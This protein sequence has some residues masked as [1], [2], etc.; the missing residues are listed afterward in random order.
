MLQSDR[1][2]WK[3]LVIPIALAWGLVPRAAA[4]AEPVRRP[5]CQIR[6]QSIGL[7]SSGWTR[8]IATDPHDENVLWGVAD[9][10]GGI[11]RTVNGGRSWEDFTE[12]AIK[13]TRCGSFSYVFV[14]P[15]GPVFV[16]TR[17]A[18]F[19]TL[20]QGKGWKRAEIRLERDPMWM[21][22]QPQRPDLVFLVDNLG[23]VYRSRDRG[24]TWETVFTQPGKDDLQKVLEYR[25]AGYWAKIRA[26]PCPMSPGY[27]LYRSHPY[28]GVLASHDEGQTWSAGNAG[29]PHKQVVSIDYHLDAQRAEL[30]L[31]ALLQARLSARGDGW[32]GGV[33]VSADGGKSWFPRNRGIVTP[34]PPKHLA[35][36]LP[37]F[38]SLEVSKKVRGLAYLLGGELYA[39]EVA[40]LRSEDAG[41]NW[42]CVHI[43]YLNV[44]TDGKVR[45]LAR[46]PYPGMLSLSASNP[47][48]FY[49]NAC[50]PMFR[51]EK[52][53]AV[54]R[55]IEYD[56]IDPETGKYRWLGISHVCTRGVA[57]DPFKNYVHTINH[58]VGYNRADLDQGIVDFRSLRHSP[59]A[60]G[61]AI[62]VDPAN[63]GWV[64]FGGSEFSAYSEKPQKGAV[65]ASTDYGRTIAFST[66]GEASGLPSG[67]IFDLALDLSG[68][69]L[70]RRLYA[71]VGG[72][73]VFASRD[74]GRTWQ[75]IHENLPAVSDDT[76]QLSVHRLHVDSEGS[77][78]AVL[79]AGPPLLAFGRIGDFTGNRVFRRTVA[80]GLWEELPSTRQFGGNVFDVVS[81][82]GNPQVLY[83][84]AY[85]GVFQSNNAGQTWRRV[86]ENIPANIK[87]PCAPYRLA[88]HPKKPDRVW[89]MFSGSVRYED[90]WGVWV[91]EDA[92]ATW[93]EANQG[94]A[95]F[96]LSDL[97][98]DPK[99]PN[100]VLVAT[101]GVGCFRGAFD[102][103]PVAP[104]RP[105]AWQPVKIRPAANAA[106]LIRNGSAEEVALEK[107]V[108]W[109]IYVGQVGGPVVWG[110]SAEGFR[111]SKCAFI[112]V[113]KL[114]PLTSRSRP[115]EGFIG[116]ALVPAD[117]DGCRARGAYPAEPGKAYYLSF[118]IKG[119][120]PR[121]AIRVAGW[122]SLEP[123]DAERST[124]LAT[125]M[126]FVNPTREWQ[127]Y[128][129]FFLTQRGT[130]AFA[131]TFM[132]RGYEG[133]GF[134]PGQRVYVDDVVVSPLDTTAERAPLVK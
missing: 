1:S 107:P 50:S 2:T 9:M 41:Q 25:L 110:T 70:Q 49:S 75:K 125:S 14:H 24:Q 126:Q 56:V 7:A 106:N 134:Q 96:G 104:V 21:E 89:V 67:Y 36:H 52:R 54:A 74:G 130:R 114:Y 40:L 53:G 79:Y 81:R 48:V 94:L 69:A 22:F 100:V 10:G 15:Q 29:L 23:S 82:P 39:R 90:K 34:V 31:Y 73:G 47:D 97:A 13:D 93:K 63:P 116:I 44:N 131:P 68:P 57:A 92:G 86:L 129:M 19:Y 76:M 62:L 30:L 51:F 32:E 118:R 28:F 6:W 46:I 109:N 132:A 5:A 85:T 80:S 17:Q 72:H 37:Q 61:N 55:Q 78:Y 11:V 42:T 58:D 123:S 12:R 128:E 102:E 95:F 60:Q 122:K 59:W 127:R 3:W 26:V 105:A 38:N 43:N 99:D 16:G 113:P 115:G 83:A 101:N 112:E 65:F 87:G 98:I 33:Y 91:S 108:G 88:I 20:D 84:A 71:A 111:G 66:Q 35:K 133:D 27:V 124:D 103:R 77:L 117:N 8:S 64:W 120:V 121:V 45:E 4:C 18:I 119:D